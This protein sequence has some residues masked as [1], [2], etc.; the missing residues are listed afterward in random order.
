[1]GYYRNL[2]VLFFC[3]LV[4]PLGLFL[5]DV[6]YQQ[7]Q[8]QFVSAKN[9][10][11][12]SLP[13]QS[14]EAQKWMH[15]KINYWKTSPLFLKLEDTFYPFRE[16]SE[17][18]IQTIQ[19]QDDNNRY[20][21]QL[22]SISKNEDATY[23]R[24]SKAFFYAERM[25]FSDPNLNQILFKNQAQWFSI[26][27]SELNQKIKI[28][29]SSYNTL[30]N[31]MV[32]MST[33]VLLT[34]FVFNLSWLDIIKAFALLLVS[35]IVASQ[36]FILSLGI[37]F[38][39]IFISGVLITSKHRWGNETT[40]SP[41]IGAAIVLSIMS[42]SLLAS[43]IAIIVFIVSNQFQIIK[44]MLLS[45]YIVHPLGVA[46][47][48]NQWPK[49]IGGMIFFLGLTLIV[50]P[51]PLMTPLA[52]MPPILFIFMLSLLGYIGLGVLFPSDLKTDIKKWVGLV[53]TGAGLYGISLWI[54][55]LL[56]LWV[57]EFIWW[58]ILMWG[59]F[60]L[61]IN[62]VKWHQVNRESK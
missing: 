14:P 38:H 25:K 46:L 26:F 17:N 15:L 59:G 27:Q 48:K 11:K 16:W 6:N 36:H 60:I 44:R 51:L 18:P 13:F 23:I 54:G 1:M 9:K 4:I 62:Q 19:K 34:R 30:I 12:T 41:W 37:P 24:A 40:L 56:F 8:A 52:Y 35:L 39:W 5:F 42:V 22:D 43:G 28:Q 7:V 55:P 50:G 33:M 3:L 58:P 20:Q 49:L 45:I 29:N 32:L 31:L 21:L 10:Y 57:F 47:H 2:F 53:C 61:L